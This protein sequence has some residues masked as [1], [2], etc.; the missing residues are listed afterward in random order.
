ME[1]KQSIH[2]LENS[3]QKLTRVHS[4]ERCS[5]TNCAIHNMS[6][7]HMRSWPQIFREDNATMERVCSHGI[8]HP[9]PDSPNADWAHGCDGCCDPSSVPEPVEEKTVEEKVTEY[10]NWLNDPVV[11]SHALM[12]LAKDVFEDIFVDPSDRV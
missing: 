4:A 7:H 3:N 2:Q 10:Y 6:N 8:G 11:K 12:K 9:D 1:T 5:G